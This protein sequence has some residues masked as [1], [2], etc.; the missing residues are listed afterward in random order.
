MDPKELKKELITSIKKV[1]DE[2]LLTDLYCLLKNVENDK[3]TVLND[4]DVHN[5]LTAFSVALDQGQF[6]SDSKGQDDIENWLYI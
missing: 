2:Q 3:Q 4:Q 5:E 6:Y 1:N